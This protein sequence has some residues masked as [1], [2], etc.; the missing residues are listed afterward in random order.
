[1]QLLSIGSHVTIPEDVTLD[2]RL[3]GWQPPSGSYTVIAAGVDAGQSNAPDAF[4]L[5]A[6]DP[7]NPIATSC[8]FSE[9]LSERSA[10]FAYTVAHVPP[11]SEVPPAPAWACLCPACGVERPTWIGR[12][13]SGALTGYKIQC[14]AFCQAVLEMMGRDDGLR[15]TGYTAGALEPKRDVLETTKP[16]PMVML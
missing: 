15:P 2:S 14:C 12:G 9:P 5:L 16:D 1:M 13:S 6:R 11:P 7:A 4:H 10:L 8:Q 3:G